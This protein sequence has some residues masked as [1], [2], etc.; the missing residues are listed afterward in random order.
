MI[1]RL[2]D[3][4]DPRHRKGALR[5]GLVFAAL[6]FIPFLGSSG[7][8]SPWEAQYAEV[9]REMT[10]NGNYVYPKYRNTGF[11]SKP[12]LTMWLTSPGLSLTGGWKADGMI[13]PWTPFAVRLPM[14]LLLLFA[15]FTMFW[16]MDR[17]FGHRVAL[18]AVI[19]AATSPFVLLAGRQAVTD[20]PFFAMVSAALFALMGYLFGDEVDAEAQEASVDAPAVW[21]L[22][23][24]VGVLVEL[25]TGTL[26]PSVHSGWR[27]LLL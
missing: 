6:I 7:L 25:L 18:S 5:F 11:F 23:A 16:S 9:A 13:S 17:I 10:A 14:V 27:L 24:L 26:M 4:F 20:M 3:Y 15:L 12:I 2:T 21:V 22:A 19:V 1:Q 8:T